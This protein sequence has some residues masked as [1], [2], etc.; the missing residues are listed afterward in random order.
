MHNRYLYRLQREWRMS[1]VLCALLI[2][3]L[4]YSPFWRPA[5][6][7][8]FDAL[9]RYHG[10]QPSADVVVITID[11][12]SITELGG[13]PVK[14]STYVDLLETLATPA[15]KPRVVGVNLLLIDATEHDT[16]LAAALAH[17]AAVLPVGFS[18]AGDG[19]QVPIEPAGDLAQAAR[20]A[21]INAVFER[22]GSVR[23]IR[24]R[25]AGYLHFALAMV[26]AALMEAPHTAEAPRSPIRRLHIMDPGTP[27]TTVSLSDALHPAYPREQFKDKYVLLGVTSPTLGDRFATLYSGTYNS[28]TPGVL[29]LASAVQAQLHN[30]FIDM[31]ASGWVLAFNLVALG[32]MLGSVLYLSPVRALL[33]SAA[34]MLWWLLLSDYVLASRGWWL[35]PTPFFA[36]V[37]VF[38]PL[39]AWRRMQ[40]MA[41]V[42]YRKSADLSRAM[43]DSLTAP[44]ARAGEF[45][46]QHALLLDRAVEAAS[47]E[48]SL[49]HSVIDQMPEAVALFHIE[50]G[51]LLCN[52]RF[53]ALW[54]QPEPPPQGLR[55]SA[56]GPWLG[57]AA[58]RLQHTQSELVSVP[59]THGVG[60]PIEIM[61]KSSPIDSERLGRLWVLVLSDVT[62]L[63][64]SQAQRDK[65]LQFLSHDMRTPLASILTL[66]RH[67]QAT[68]P[69]IDQHARTLLHMMD[70]FCMAVQADAPTYQRRAELLDTFVDDAIDRV[71]DLAQTKHIVIQF[72]PSEAPVFVQ[73]NAQL[74]VRAL[75]NLMQNAVKFA[76][77]H[78]CVEVSVH[79]HAASL[80]PGP[81]VTVTI[82]NAVDDS[83]QDTSLPGFGLGLDF[84]D[85]VVAKHGGHLVRD[86]PPHGLA[87]VTLALPC[88]PETLPEA[89]T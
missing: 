31:A 49:L 43:P 20:L 37:L 63:R 1:A 57:V 54:P 69:K 11:D 8:V 3:L 33:W 72:D 75:T 81:G 6:D 56:L 19:V 82:T 28:N 16:R 7:L 76:P 15:Y 26:Q 44:Q 88:S 53:A 55:L 51:M 21:H 62:E 24:Q 78:S 60:G 40:A 58:E 87:R 71:A 68:G 47:G 12:R 59:R 32:L 22:D 48:L 38:H 39:W 2:G 64:Q 14:R 30:T 42:I 79:N 45:V 41:N 36:A 46:V 86:I 74:L 13:W 29:I 17:H 18:D 34:L 35:D 73:A 66:N 84:V 5:G 89:L 67:G 52:S 4:C 65:A 25:D 61:L 50:Q 27:F 10:V 83:Y 77:L 80:G 85:K 70:D 9:L 23:G